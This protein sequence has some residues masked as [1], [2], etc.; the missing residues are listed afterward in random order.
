MQCAVSNRCI[1]WFY[2]K[3]RIRI[4]TSLR[5]LRYACSSPNVFACQIEWLIECYFYYKNRDSENIRMHYNSIFRCHIVIS[6]I[7]VAS[8]KFFFPIPNVSIENTS[9]FRIS[10]NAMKTYPYFVLQAPRFLELHFFTC[11]GAD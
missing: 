7:N 3:R 5:N 10:Y 9:Y 11:F 8:S 6:F 4:F 1:T 2:H